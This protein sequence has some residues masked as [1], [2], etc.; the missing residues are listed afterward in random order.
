MKSNSDNFRDSSVIGI[1]KRLKSKKI[2][3]II[4]EPV[5][6]EKLFF[7]SSVMSNLNEFKE[8]CDIIIANR[9]AHDLEDVQHKVYT[10]D[11]FH[12]N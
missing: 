4:F 5:L 11:L 7:N 2:K 9:M 6:K 10:R 8:K 1:I 3:V 12:N